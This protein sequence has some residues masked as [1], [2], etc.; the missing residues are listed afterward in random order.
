MLVSIIPPFFNEELTLACLLAR[1][2]A[3]ALPA[4]MRRV[5]RG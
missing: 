3:A 1:V 2:E 4:G 5:F